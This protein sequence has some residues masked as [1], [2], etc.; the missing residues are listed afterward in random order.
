M[1]VESLFTYLELKKNASEMNDQIL[2][3][4]ISRYRPTLQL[5]RSEVYNLKLL[6]PTYRATRGLIN[7]VG[8]SF[9]FLFGTMD[10]DDVEKNKF[11]S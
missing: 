2:F 5:T 1:M 6:L 9:K 4:E 11:S 3:H 7:E 8:D 10:D